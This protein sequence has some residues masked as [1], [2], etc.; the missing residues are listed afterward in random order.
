MPGRKPTAPEIRVTLALLDET[1]R[2][3]AA[4][5]IGLD[6]RRLRASPGKRAWSAVEVFAHLRAC[7]DL[8]T[9]SIYAMLTEHDP[10]LPLLDERRWAS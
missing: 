10:A 8:W 9:H 2:R 4:C 5:T 6:E 3:I 1:P 7:D